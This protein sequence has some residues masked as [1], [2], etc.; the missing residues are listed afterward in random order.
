MSSKTEAQKLSD[1]FASQNKFNNWE[2]LARFTGIDSGTLTHYRKGTRPVTL[3]SHREA[4]FKATGIVD[5]RSAPPITTTEH[6]LSNQTEI[7]S[8]KQLASVLRQFLEQQ[9]MTVKDAAS[10]S[11]ISLVSFSRYV[12]GTQFPTGDNAR[13][14]EQL[15][16]CRLS[17]PTVPSSGESGAQTKARKILQLLSA[18]KRE[19]D[20]FAK[21]SPADRKELARVVK[22]RDVGYIM[23]L[24]K[25]LYNEDEFQ[26]WLFFTSYDLQ[27][28]EVP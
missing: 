5:F 28:S 18:L 2:A 12:R 24:F 6:I 13:K 15:L 10:K 3:H 14:I 21:G 22:G 9:T 4:L 23:A 16:Q 19:L 11:N 26:R 17:L 27:G 8:T 25:A 20:F 1:W 7:A